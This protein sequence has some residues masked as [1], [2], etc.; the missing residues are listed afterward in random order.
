M[1]ILAQQS[2]YINAMPTSRPESKWEVS[3]SDQ[4]P[5][6]TVPTQADEYHIIPKKR[7]VGLE[8]PIGN[9]YSIIPKE[10]I[11]PARP[12]QL[13]TLNFKQNRN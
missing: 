8:F 1:V 2:P 10:R 4:R 6:P 5:V 13:F 9:I 3:Q 7:T 12:L 11:P